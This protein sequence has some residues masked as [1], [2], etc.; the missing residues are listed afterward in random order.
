MPLNL[1]RRPGRPTWYI[2][3]T[4]AGRKI[5][6]STGVTRK[7]DAELIRAQREREILDEI[8]LGRRATYTFA[9]AVIAYLEANGDRRFLD[10]ILAHFGPERRLH[11]I[12]NESAHAAA[13]ALY[14]DAAPATQNR[15][16]I[17]P[18]SAVYMRAAL[19]DIVP[20]RR[21]RKLAQPKGRRTRWL[22]PLEA[23]RLLEAAAPHLL[24]ILMFLIGTG[25]RPN[26]ALTLTRDR[27]HLEAGQAWLTET[28]TD[29][30]RMVRFP[31][32]TAAVLE[33]MPEREIPE[34]FATPK[35]RA[36][37]VSKHRGGQI[38]AAFRAACDLA[39]LGRDVTPY[40]LRH[41][42]ATWHSAQTGDLAELM[43][44]GGWSKADMALHYRKA[45]PDDLGPRLF[46]LGWNFTKAARPIQDRRA[47]PMR[48]A[49]TT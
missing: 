45:A 42:W 15:Q 29:R 40:T 41:T 24:P 9:D 8:T 20:P 27:L 30:P 2:R 39:G 12:T 44:L 10:R 32:R 5:R 47:R 49:T 26:E 7:A 36:Y 3:G 1:E 28:K 25:A 17:T 11:T 22:D 46:D 6:E 13:R 19:D 4:L 18:I 14:P 34:V 48:L 23:E 43:D 37:I 31:A 16:V 38:S 35:G 21:F 33:A